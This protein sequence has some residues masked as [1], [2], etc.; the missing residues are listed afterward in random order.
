M[1]IPII[2]VVLL[3][4]HVAQNDARLWQVVKELRELRKI[5][6]DKNNK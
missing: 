6:I 4:I 2:I 5:L 1:Q 3:I